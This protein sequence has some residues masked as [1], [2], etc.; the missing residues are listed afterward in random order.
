MPDFPIESPRMQMNS[1][2][3]VNRVMQ[4]GQDA[5]GKR[6]KTETQDRDPDTGMLRW[7]YE[8]MYRGSNF[9][10][11]CTITAV[12]EVGAAEKPDPAPMT[13]V[14]FEGLRVSVFPNRAGG[15]SE[16]WAADA[17]AEMQQRLGPKSE[18]SGSASAS[19]D[20]SSSASSKSS[21]SSSS[22]AA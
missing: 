6:F 11:D 5:D 2:G 17:I 22:A 8:V 18:S 21:S 14:S 13:P 12:V 4:W 20:A 9:G 1:S 3:I 7:G 19:K 10:E 15:L 16:R